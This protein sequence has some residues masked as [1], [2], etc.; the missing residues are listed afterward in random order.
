VRLSVAL[1]M[2]GAWA[3]PDSQVRVA[4][5]AEALGYHSPWTF[6]RLLYAVKPRNDARSHGG[7]RLVPD[8]GGGGGTFRRAG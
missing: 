5:A 1:P 3:T 7:L 4:Q 8:G 6:Q 2:A